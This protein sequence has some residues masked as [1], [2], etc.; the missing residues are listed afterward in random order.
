MTESWLLISAFM[1]FIMQAGFLCLETGKIRSKN[2]INVAAKNISDFI[3]STIVFW[4]FGFALM[5]GDS[6]NGWF[7]TSEF[8]FGEENTPY[9][10]SFF[11]FQL[12]FCGTAATLLSGA[13]AERM[14]FVGYLWITVIL[15]AFIYPI[16]GHWAWASF[17]NPENLGWLQKLGFVDFAGSTVVHSVGGSVALAAVI[18]IGPRIGRFDNKHDLPAGSNLPLTVLGA[19]FLWLG[20]FGFNGGSTL[21]FD[22]NV[23]I[24]ILNTFIS[25]VWGG[26]VSSICHYYFKRFIDVTYILNGVLAGL[27]AITAG[28][29]AMSPADSAIIGS[30]AGLILYAGTHLLEKLKLDDAL[31]VVPVHLFA[32]I[33]GTLAVALFADLAAL[34]TGLSRSEQFLS[35]L[36]GVAAINIYSF[37]ASFALIKLV[38]IF[39]N[40]RVTPEQEMLGMNISEHRASTE[41]IDLLGTMKKQQDGGEFSSPVPVEPFTEVGQIAQQYNQVI[42]R[43]NNE[44][45]QR[46]EAIHNFKA[47]EKR[48][49]AILNS[50]MDSII[51]IDFDGKIIEFN[52]AAEKT[53]GYLKDYVLNR[54]FIDLFIDPSEQEAVTN[55]LK[56]KFSESQGL[57]YNRRNT[58]FLRR[59]SGEKFPAEITITGASLGSQLKNE[60]TL[61][62]RDTT[63][64]TKL[65]DKLKHLAYSDP[66]TGLYNRT[67]LI[68]SIQN[69]ITEQEAEGLAVLF[70][71]LDHFKNINDTLGHAAGDKL[72]REVA[73][74]LTQVTESSDVIA[75]WGGD[76]FVVLLNQ[77]SKID[78]IHAKANQVLQQM[79][80]PITLEGREINIPTSIGISLYTESQLDASKLIQQADIAMYHAKQAGRDNYQIFNQEMMTKSVRQFNFE[81]EMKKA[82]QVDD[83]IHMVYQSKVDNNKAVTGL[84]ALIRW[85]HPVEGL[86]SPAEFIPL[87]EESNLIINIDRKVIKVVL[88]QLNQW[89][90][91]GF[92]LYP[93]SINLSGKHL[94]SDDLISFVQEQLNTYQIDGSLIEFEIT[95]GV[96]LTDIE[97]SIE[98]MTALKS[99]DITLS[100]DDF[101]TGYSSLNYLKRLPI[102]VLKIDRSFVDECA[103]TIEDGQI[104]ATVINLAQNLGL[105]AVAEGVET[106]E[107]WQFLASKGCEIFQGYYFN[108]PMSAEDTELKLLSKQ[109]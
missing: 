90:Q 4:L 100:V 98:A 78:E 88:Q 54:S 108:K 24:I 73:E 68:E 95:E 107:Q 66:L 22:D 77:I 86:I 62:I 79:R 47:S 14:T 12:M 15:A 40:L 61:H 7:G 67:Y 71:D 83:Q 63:R 43:V 87:A 17:F 96:L 72:L 65:R 80:E 92:S 75:R 49:S 97:R 6:Y 34:E 16:A 20:W 106:A 91:E 51:S 25:A 33:W 93:V 70:M 105:E 53:F 46:D 82:L 85:H 35:Q 84:E 81:Q 37:V 102:D 29:F 19:L 42:N 18:I 74:R 2:S 9:Q 23:P 28:C 10:I 109:N 38:S 27:V 30:I 26:L 76:E 104:C 36:T 3:L 52:P 50:S 101:G 1:V 69:T 64:Q 58:T 44:I 56:H 103:N 89:Q 60:F 8:F 11:V 32:G 31:G 41:L 21:T 59:S 39:I 57:L 55:S 48:K 94:V 13:V 5:F 45:T 99:L